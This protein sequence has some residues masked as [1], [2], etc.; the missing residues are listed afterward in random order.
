MVS[1]VTVTH[2]RINHATGS[3]ITEDLRGTAPVD[4]RVIIGERVVN[5]VS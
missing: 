3:V 5:M 4:V 2:S 1:P